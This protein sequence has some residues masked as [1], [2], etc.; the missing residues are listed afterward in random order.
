MAGDGAEDAFATAMAIVGS[1]ADAPSTF[2]EGPGFD[3]AAALRN[4][5]GR[6]PQLLGQFTD[7][8]L[9]AAASDPD[10][11]ARRLSMELFGDPSG[12]TAV[13]R[14]DELSRE[15]QES[16]AQRLRD[17]G[18]QPSIDDAGTEVGPDHLDRMWVDEQPTKRRPSG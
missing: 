18:V 16:I 11:W 3:E 10:A 12:G 14:R 4:T 6:L 7:P 8:A 5:F 9:D 15:I 17:A 13:R 2:P 1:L